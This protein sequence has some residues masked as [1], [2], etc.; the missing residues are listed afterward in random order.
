M[1]EMERCFNLIEPLV[2]QIMMSFMGPFLA[3]AA[4]EQETKELTNIV[5]SFPS[6]DERKKYRS[7]KSEKETRRAN[8]EKNARLDK[9]KRAVFGDG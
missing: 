7:W 3:K 4:W 1:D 8:E 9:I 2:R 5:G 6:D